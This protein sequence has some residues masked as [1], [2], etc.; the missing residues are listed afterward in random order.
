MTGTID[1][2]RHALHASITL[3]NPT[4]RNALNQAMFIALGSALAELGSD[5]SLRCIVL[6]GAGTQAFGSGGDIEEY[7]QKRAEKRQAM[8]YAE[9]GYRTMR[10]LRDCPIPVVAAI[11]GA[12]VGG[13]FQLAGLCDIRIC[14]D[15]SRF[16]LPLTKL[17]LTLSYFEM[18][19]LRRYVGR[20]TAAELLLEG[21]LLA[22]P[23]ALAK[24][25][26]HRVVSAAEF[27]DAVAKTVARITQGAPLAARAHKKFL[28][29]L[30]RPE[31]LSPAEIDEPYACFD[32]ED[33]RIGYQAF[34]GG[35]TPEFVG[36]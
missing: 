12:C 33:Y 36:R 15:D 1:V 31:P 18:E 10:I 16:G 35:K 22:A 20:N 4:K 8:A 14:T 24:G 23:E 11:R 17:G 2:Q 32:T 30:D 19:N 28:Q 34:I 21:R 27:D 9:D 13:A 3:N 5:T 25:L 26:V 6:T 29:R 7:A